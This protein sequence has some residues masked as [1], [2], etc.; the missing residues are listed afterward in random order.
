MWSFVFGLVGVATF[1]AVSP[2]LQFLGRHL[3]PNVAPVSIL[4][5]AVVIAHVVSSLLGTIFLH[6]FVYWN[7]AAIFCF[8]VMSYVYVFGG[9]Y[10]SISLRLLMDLSRRPGRTVEFSDIADRQIPEI[11][12]ERTVIL[13]GGGL[14][15]REGDTY[16]PTPAGQRLA[17]RIARIRRLFAI[18]DTGLYDFD[19]K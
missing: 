5:I 13:I 18:G 8:A 1:V 10:K 19:T 6:P 7:A 17:G 16:T 15:S 12:T 9:V 14:V 4:A 11:F 3:T 2:L